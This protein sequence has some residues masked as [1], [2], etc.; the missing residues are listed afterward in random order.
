MAKTKQRQ[1]RP[2]KSA[3]IDEALNRFLQ[4]ER[5]LV[6]DRVA[7]V[8]RANS[9]YPLLIYASPK[10]MNVDL[11]V[12]DGTLWATQ[13]QMADM[14]GVN[15]PAIHKHLT[16]IFN[17]GELDRE[18]TISKMEI[19]QKEGDREVRREPEHYN[20]NAI[21]SVGYRIESKIGTMFRIWAT[22]KIVQILTK[23]FY[24]DKELL[25]NQ[26]EPSALD[27]FREIARE[28]RTSIRNSYRE[29][30]R[31]CTLCADYDG[32][33]SS[34]REFFMDMENRLLWA[35]SNK[36]APQLILER[37]DADKKDLGLTYYAG[38][39]GPTQ[40][41]VLVGNN[42]LTKTEAERKNRITEMWLTYVEEQLDQGRLPTMEA[43]REK[44]LGFIKFNQWPILTTRGRYSRD[45]ANAYA[46]QQ[47]AIYKG[48]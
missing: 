43:V 25:K 7:L 14:F 32:K 15:V 29:V 13:K 8:E 41:D 18:A 4:T 47:L 28:I 22:D 16:N 30:L 27:E 23:G 37:C 20:L 10:G 19:V 45:D 24:V 46:L 48:I 26:G 31:L 36:T 1:A 44:L 9:Q 11:T 39:K 5:P 2:I 21:I 17:E 35:A 12:R 34:A 3:E 42:Y 6:D 38:K 40:R 33:S